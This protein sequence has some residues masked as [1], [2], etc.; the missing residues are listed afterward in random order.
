ML[1]VGG[2]L[3]EGDAELLEVRHRLVEAAARQHVGEAVGVVGDGFLAGVLRQVAGGAVPLDQA[4]LGWVGPAED[5]EQ[6]GLAR[7][8]AADEAD[9]VARADLEGHPVDDRLAADL[10]DE[11]P[12]AQHRS[13]QP[14][15]GEASDVATGRARSRARVI[16]RHAAT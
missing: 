14:P 12:H 6:R 11:V 10:D 7:A 5:L 2:V 15:A 13:S 4:G 9:L 16:S 8:V 3:L 1:R